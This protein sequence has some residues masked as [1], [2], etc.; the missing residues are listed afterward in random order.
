MGDLPPIGA[1]APN[2]YGFDGNARTFSRPETAEPDEAAPRDRS[3]TARAAP[4]RET[5]LSDEE[6]RR[7]RELQQRDREVR[8]HEMAHVAVGGDLVLRG[9]QYE[10]ETG[11]DGIRYAVGGDVLIDTSPGSTPEETLDKAQRIIATALAPAD[12]SPQDRQ[13]AAKATQMAAEARVEL[14]LEERERMQAGGWEDDR[15]DGGRAGTRTD[16][17]PSQFDANRAVR[18][19]RDVAGTAGAIPG[20]T[21]SVF[22]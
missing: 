14:A 5:E 1:F 20:G 17:E 6:L 16:R 12:P 4:V 13:V 22:G 3:T 7:V 2:P 8:A 11:P 18:A 19:Y 9:A 21:I 10:Y 15:S